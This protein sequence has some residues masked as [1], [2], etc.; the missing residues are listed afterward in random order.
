[1]TPTDSQHLLRVS[2]VADRLALSRA[3]AYRLI[4]QG[5]IPTIRIGASIRVSADALD[6]CIQDQAV[7]SS[8]TESR[9]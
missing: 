4:Q 6:R 9:P 7:A 3:T 8:Q 5:L 2:E 1:M